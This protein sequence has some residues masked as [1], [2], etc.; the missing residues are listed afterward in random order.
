[1]PFKRNSY[2]G[3]TER[4]R[5]VVERA[6]AEARRRGQSHIAVEHLLLGLVLGE[7][8]ASIVLANLGA[9]AGQV[10]AAVESRIAGESSPVDGR[11]EL[12]QRAQAVIESAVRESKRL[13]H[14]YVG[15]EHLLLGL[16]VEGESIAARILEE[17]GVT[18]DRARAETERILAQPKP[19]GNGL[20]R[21]HLVLPEDL[22]R[23]V[24]HLAVSEQTTFVDVLRRFIKLGLLATRAQAT[25]GS[26][27]LIRE[28]DRE[29]E[30][31]L[32]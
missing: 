6:E 7:G 19:S 26:A 1:M 20:K 18:L 16:L 12:N 9:P 31:M 5:T 27:L 24:E 15:T 30:I 21:Y 23:E 22:Y 3:F 14:H 32:L 29:R 10:A 13:R 28:G 2:Q 17:T 25:P 4:A 11:L 8:L